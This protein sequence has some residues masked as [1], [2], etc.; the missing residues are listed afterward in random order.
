MTDRRKAARDLR[1]EAAESDFRRPQPDQLGNGEETD[2]PFLANYG[3]GLPHDDAGEVE[4]AAYRALLRAL[5]THRAEDFERVPRGVPD[6]RPFT[7]PQAGLAYDLQGPD[8]QSLAMPPAPRIDS[9]ENSAEMVELYWMALCRDVRFTDFH[10]D[11]VVADAA[12]DLS[13]LSDF[14]GPKRD[15]AVTP[16]T[17]F[18]GFTTGDL[19]GPYVSQFLLRDFR[20]GT[21]A[22]SQRQDTVKP[23]QDFLTDFDDWLDVQRGAGRRAQRR[24][25]PRYL[26]T[27]RDLAHYVHFDALYQAYLNACLILLELD[28]PL[29]VGNP[30]PHTANQAGF[31]TYGGPH[32]LSL[33]TEVATRAL[34]AVWYQKWFVHRRLRPEA[35]GG[36]IEAHLTG[37]RDYPMID[38]QVLESGGLKATRERWDTGL[39]PQA[40]PEGSPTHP[41]Y[42]AGHATVAGA[43]VTILKAWFDES[44]VL[45]EPV[46]PDRTGERLVPYDGPGADRLTLAGEL[47]KLAANIAIGRSFGGVHWRSDY[48]ESV[49]LGEAVAIGILREL[50]LTTHEDAGF[51]LRR[52]D[53]TTL[54]I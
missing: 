32:I 4:P 34:K 13:G 42:G 17:L 49:K 46:V 18:R 31:G 40:Y 37:R 2:Y 20:Y 15:A 14:R 47:D 45:P 1:I 50:K 35:F 54:Q 12:T 16:A 22:I 36:R 30:Y 38:P 7:N 27:P 8:P 21:L 10:R 26:Q 51:T 44:Y 24:G 48:T 6:G 23:G 19:R 43:C 52:F 28:A 53:G 33:V 9:A 29:D 25:R 11:P 3:K 39:L 5:S 41:A